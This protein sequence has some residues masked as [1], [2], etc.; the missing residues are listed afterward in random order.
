MRECIAEA[1]RLPPAR[2]GVKATTHE[3]MG[4]VGR[5]E[6]VAALAVAGDRSRRIG[7]PPPPPPPHPP[8]PPPPPPPPARDRMPAAA[9][10]AL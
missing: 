7:V 1:L 10:G 9:H 2:V 6:D 5:G 8:P 4:F 3:H